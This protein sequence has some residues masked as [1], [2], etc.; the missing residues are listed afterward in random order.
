MAI[1]PFKIELIKEE[2]DQKVSFG[3]RQFGDIGRDI[4][5]VKRA[6]GQIIPYSELVEDSDEDPSL[7]RE[8]PNSWFDCITGQIST[9]REAATFDSN[10]QNYLMKFQLDNQ[11]YILCY[12]FIKFNIAET[13][14]KREDFEERRGSVDKP[15][16]YN[17]GRMVQAAGELA[18]R[19]WPSARATILGEFTSEEVMGTMTEEDEQFFIALQID[20]MLEMFARDFGTISE[21]TLAVMH[22]WRPRSS[23]GNTSYY[24]DE[25]SRK[26]STACF[27]FLLELLHTLKHQNALT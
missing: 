2:N 9:S 7:E 14:E 18:D 22:G 25:Q 23:I 5:I 11:F 6:L 16:W 15:S 13:L 4:M 19:G 26:Q 8:D 3:P 27:F 17:P 1:R 24:H 10:L 20:V 12:N 21:A